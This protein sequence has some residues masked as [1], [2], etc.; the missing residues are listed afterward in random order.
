VGLIPS[1]IT[2]IILIYFNS[3]RFSLK[4]RVFCFFFLLGLF[5]FS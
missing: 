4:R 3:L 2:N 1:A 5:V